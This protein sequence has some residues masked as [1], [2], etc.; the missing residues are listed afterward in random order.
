MNTCSYLAADRNR[1]DADAI[2][3]LTTMPIIYVEQ[4]KKV[5]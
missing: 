3:R 1:T 2:H 4:V 5:C